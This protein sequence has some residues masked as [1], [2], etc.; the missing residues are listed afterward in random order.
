MSD[1]KRPSNDVELETVEIEEF[2]KK[3]EEPPPAKAY[4]VRIDK[5]KY[6]F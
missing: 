4:K 1:E 2:G 6:I 3:N 5:K